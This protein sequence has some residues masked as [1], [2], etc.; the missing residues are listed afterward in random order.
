MPKFRLFAE[1]S[2]NGFVLDE[3]DENFIN[4]IKDLCVSDLCIIFVSVCHG[5]EVLVS[6]ALV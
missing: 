4:F 1:E 3:F 5:K 6:E 2:A